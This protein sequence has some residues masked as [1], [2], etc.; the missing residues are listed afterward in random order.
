M[1]TLQTEKINAEYISCNKAGNKSVL[2]D[3]TW[4]VSKT[5]L[6]NNGKINR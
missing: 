6:S 3:F 4:I 1:Y 5:I 2:N